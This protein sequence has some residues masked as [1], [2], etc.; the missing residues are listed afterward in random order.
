MKRNYFYL[1]KHANINLLMPETK[2]TTR[3]FLARFHYLYFTLPCSF[4]FFNLNSRFFNSKTTPENTKYCT[5]N[6]EEFSEQWCKEKK[7]ETLKNLPIYFEDMS[8]LKNKKYFAITQII[9]TDPPFVNLD[10]LY[11]VA[12]IYML[13]NKNTKKF[14]IG[15]SLNLKSR[16]SSYL[17]ISRLENNKSSRIHRALLKYGFDRFSVSILDFA[18]DKANLNSLENFYI[19]VFKPQYNIARSLFNVDNNYLAEPNSEWPAKSLIIPTKITNLLDKCLDPLNLDWHIFLVFFNKRKGFFTF[20]FISPDYFITA[21]TR[22]W[23][24]GDV[25]KKNGYS[26][27]KW[28]KSNSIDKKN[29][30]ID[31]VTD[32]Y[33]N[34]DKKDIL[35]FFPPDKKDFV[36][37]SL[38]NK[39]KAWKK[40]YSK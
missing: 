3:L 6:S 24:D 30:Y 19:K 1:Y 23:S 31:I 38:K 16:L 5:E 7:I 40:K 34:L 37:N 13:K 12:G 11:N 25:T 22:G 9:Y 27:E 35:I 21:D 28:K 2:G 26:E 4:S 15:K 8:Q 39:I 10:S 17:I 29:L 32:G 36:K 20:T 14:Y 18:Y 33:K